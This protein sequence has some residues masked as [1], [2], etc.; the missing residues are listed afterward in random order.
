MNEA[1]SLSIKNAGIIFKPQPGGQSL[2]LSSSADFVLY[3]GQA[4]GGK[5]Y[6]LLLGK[7]RYIHIKGYYDVTFRREMKQIKNAGGLWNESFNIYPY[8]GGKPNSSELKWTFPSGAAISFAGLEL[9]VDKL[10]WQGS[11]I[12]ALCFDEVTHFTGTQ[13]RYMLT[14]NR[15]TCGIRP[16]IHA[17]CNPEADSWVKRF[18][19]WYLVP[20][21]TPDKT[22]RGI[23][24]YFGMLKDNWVFAESLEAMKDKYELEPEECKTYTFIYA[25]LDDNPK[26]LEKD[27]GYIS[28]LKLAGEIESAALLH[29]NWN[30]KKSGK[31]FKPDDFKIFTQAPKYSMKIIVAD[32]AQ[33]TKQANDFSVFQAWIKN[34]KGIYLIDQ[35][36]GKYEFPDLETLFISFANKHSDAK[37]YVEDAVSGTSLIQSVKRKIQRPINAIRRT[38]DKYTRAFDAQGYVK[39]GYVY[40]N[41]LLEYYTDFINELS[42]FNSEGDYAHDDQADCVF[43]AITILMIEYKCDMNNINEYEFKP[44]LIY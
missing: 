38:K 20:Q 44:K 6:A 31:I 39:S 5:T 11:Q 19:E 24:R 4:G 17:T 26:L 27:P 42:S 15:S 14:R 21:G 1:D 40:L 8:F 9:E 29:G 2:F 3:G 12:P 16:Y 23:I 37:L 25:T 34:E 41:P 7:L 35:V 10:K 13:F 32:T 36:R 18:V 30:I 28:N 22:K 33:K 43:D